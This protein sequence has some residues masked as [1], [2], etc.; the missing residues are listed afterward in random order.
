LKDELLVAIVNLDEELT[1]SLV[2]QQL[3]QGRTP[4]EIVEVCKK[5]VEIVGKRYSTG[6]YFLSD[7]IMTEE[8]LK[9]VMR[10]V[11]PK[12]P[13]NV[14]PN[15]CSI[16][17][18]TIEGDIHDLGKNIIIYLLRSFGFQVYDLGVDVSPEQFVKA[19]SETGAP[20]LGISVLLSFC[21]GSIKKVVDLLSEAGLR[22]KVKVVIGGYPVNEMVKEYTGADYYAHEVTQAIEICRKIFNEQ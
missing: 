2:Q 6:R 21:I 17:M 8:I 15:G 18:G 1:L 5:A 4:L 9:G 12:I 22:E 7:L 16:V 11:E 20:I 3:E 13:V 19:V 10:I 14:T